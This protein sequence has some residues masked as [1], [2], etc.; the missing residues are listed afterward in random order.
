[1]EICL[2][3]ILICRLEYAIIHK[4][5]NGYFDIER[6]AQYAQNNRERLPLFRACQQEFL[7]LFQEI[8]AGLAH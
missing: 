2:R 5:E 8:L 1:L 3:E 7:A 4:V 6:V